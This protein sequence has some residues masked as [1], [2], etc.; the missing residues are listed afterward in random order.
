MNLILIG[1]RGTGKS[2]VARILASRL[3]WETVSTDARIIEEAQL[4]IPEIVSQFGWDYFRDLETT[5][6]QGFKEKDDLVIDTGGG[7]I[8]RDVNIQ[9]LKPN[10]T[11][12]W[13]TASIETIS[14]RIAGDSQRPSLTSGKTFIEE[15]RDVLKERTPQ[16]QAAADFTIATDSVTANEVANQVLAKF[17]ESQRG[18]N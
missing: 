17:R 15:I 5:I 7:V 12:F 11:V 13:L 16:Y 2:T 3:G 4:P 9:A 8:L 10:G 18:E 14:H 1:Y 6:C